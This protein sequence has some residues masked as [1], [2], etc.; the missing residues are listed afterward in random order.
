MSSDDFVLILILVIILFFSSLF[1]SA[2]LAS[3]LRSIKKRDENKI[4]D[5]EVYVLK[6]ET[7]FDSSSEIV[8]KYFRAC[9]STTLALFIL[10]IY[11]FYIFGTMFD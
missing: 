10:T 5:S 8:R 6:N 1:T 4:S 7:N 3:L 2:V 9:V 11:L